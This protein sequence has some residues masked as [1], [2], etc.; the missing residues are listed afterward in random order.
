M[1]EKYKQLNEEGFCVTDI[2]IKEPLFNECKST[3]NNII[4]NP[5]LHSLR[6]SNFTFIAHPYTY[7]CFAKVATLDEIL[8]IP[9]YFFGGREFFLGT[10]NLRRSVATEATESTTTIYHRD[11]NLQGNTEGNFVKVFLYLTDVNENN[12]PFTYV[13][14]SNINA[15]QQR[16]IEGSYRVPE[17][18]VFTHYQKNDE[19]KFIAPKNTVI[20][21]DTTGLHKGTKVKE[22]YRDLFTMNFCATKEV[23]TEKFQVKK[24]FVDSL[25]ENKRHLFK[26]YSMV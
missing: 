4:N 14:K 1:K 16:I 17:S 2:K 20:A 3:F 22:G 5:N 13:R 25:P 12:G 10:V 11:D 9:N 18:I 23:N 26:F 6:N 8:E 21:A 19:I 24:S 7:E 15:K